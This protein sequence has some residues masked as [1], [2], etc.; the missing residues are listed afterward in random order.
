[1]DPRPPTAPGVLMAA[2]P[3]NANGA[4]EDSQSALLPSWVGLDT[5]VMREEA[6][7]IS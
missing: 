2:M 1:M 5:P 4:P 6:A 7:A 3:S